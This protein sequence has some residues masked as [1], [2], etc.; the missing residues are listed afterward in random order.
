MLQFDWFEEDPEDDLS[1]AQRAFLTALRERARTWPC[2]PNYTQLVEPGGGRET[3]GAILDVAA[4]PEKSILIT[5][6]VFFDGTSIRAGEVHN[7]S[8]VPTSDDQSRVETLE[9]TGDPQHLAQAAADWFENLL[10][11][12]L[13][14]R[15]WLRNGHV[16]REYAFSDTGTPLVGRS[17][18]HPVSIFSTPPDRVIQLRGAHPRS[19]TE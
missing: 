10:V 19:P 4:Q 18:W 15:E 7:Q 2:T 14:R 6:G 9:A 8:F 17:A 1:T 13:E 12:P 11:R 16:F 5:V 3:W